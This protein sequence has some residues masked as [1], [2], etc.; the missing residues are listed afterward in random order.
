[1][2]LL[3]SIVLLLVVG[4]A[5]AYKTYSGYQVLKT[6]P[7]TPNVMPYINKMSRIYDFWGTPVVGRPATVM[8]SPEEASVV[9]SVLNRLRISHEVM[10]EDLAPIVEQDFAE[11]ERLMRAIPRQ[12]RVAVYN[13]Y[14][15][16]DE[17][18]AHIHETVDAN[19]GVASLLDLGLSTEGRELHGIKLSNG[20]A[21]QPA[22]WFD[23]AIHA[24][25]WIAPPVCLRII[26]EVLA[27]P[28]LRDLADWYVLPIAN[29]DGYSFATT[30]DRFWRKTRRPNPG[31][32]CVGTDPNRN[33]DFLWDSAG[34]YCSET[35]PG[36][37]AFS[38]PECAG[39]GNFI[40]ANAD[41]LILYVAL[42]SYGPII[43]YPFG[44]TV[45]PV[46]N[47][48]DLLAAG[49]ASATVIESVGG[50]TYPVENS[51][52]GLY[53][54]FGASDDYAYGIGA[55]GYAYTY[56]LPGGGSG[57][58]N[59]PASAIQRVVDETWPGLKTLVEYTIANPTTPLKK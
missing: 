22:V 50:P 33:F 23:C 44:H 7:L 59:P 53:F 40:A 1:M 51:A 49:T 24:R 45:D 42:H 14:M 13:R 38:E 48:D 18:D 2:R 8:V 37:S 25:E 28:A 58:F 10:I 56:E 54:T 3:G 46:P 12:P 6:A 9:N 4:S 17:I 57:G 19:P 32:T 16:F 55:A 29:P 31:S 15:T 26:D 43:L 47:A 52:A 20:A 39:I 35:F 21:G 5:L 27:D 30:D 11:Q 34:T 36:A 41:S